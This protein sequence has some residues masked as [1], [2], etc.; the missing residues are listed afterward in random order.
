MLPQSAQAGEQCGLNEFCKYFEKCNSLF[1]KLKYS[2][3]LHKKH[4]TAICG[5]PQKTSNIY[6]PLNKT[7]YAKHM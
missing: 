7:L 1:M 5:I 2:H 3:K 6:D 4:L